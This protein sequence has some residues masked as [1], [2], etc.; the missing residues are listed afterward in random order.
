MENEHKVEDE[1]MRSDKKQEQNIQERQSRKEKMRGFIRNRVEEFKLNRQGK[2]MKKRSDVQSRY[3]RTDRLL[4]LLI[5][6]VLLCLIITWVIIL[7][8]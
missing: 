4:S 6:I 1:M 5:L 8:I 2:T 7:F 3:R